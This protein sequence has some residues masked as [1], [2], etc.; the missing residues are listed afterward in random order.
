MQVFLT[1]SVLTGN[2]ALAG[3]GGA[4][5]IDADELHQQ[6]CGFPGW[7]QGTRPGLPVH[8]R[9]N[10]PLSAFGKG[11]AW[12]RACMFGVDVCGKVQARAFCSGAHTPG[13]AAAFLLL[14][15]LH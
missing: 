2:S 5:A 13:L 10:G 8:A 9:P 7:V 1:S 3:N 15:L 11:C 12:R 6:V 14:R 4:F